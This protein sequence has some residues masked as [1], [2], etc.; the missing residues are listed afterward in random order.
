MA[1]RTV[2]CRQQLGLCYWCSEPMFTD[3]EPTHP[4]LGGWPMLWPRL[5]NAV[6]EP[7]EARPCIRVQFDIGRCLKEPSP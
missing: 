3:V 2:A 7:L 4:K 5:R 6:N 1:L